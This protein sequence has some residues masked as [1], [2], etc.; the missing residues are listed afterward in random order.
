MGVMQS[1]KLNDIY[2]NIRYSMP[3]NK[4]DPLSLD[5]TA[6]R[7]LR[8]VHEF[9]SFSHAAESLGVTQS[10]VSYGIDRMRKA[11][12][13]PLFVRQGIDIVPTD[14]CSDIVA[15]ITPMI[16]EFMALSLSKDFDPAAS[17]ATVSLSCN[18]YERV[19]LL[20]GLMR[21][22]R[23]DA[24]RLRVNI[25]SSTVRGK[26]QLDR[27]E[28]D[29]LIGPIKVM[30]GSYY[31]RRLLDDHYVAVMSSANLLAGSS[32]T[33]DQYLSAPS[34]IVTYGGTW[35]SRVLQDIEHDGQSLN[36]VMEVPS[37]AHIPSLLHQT[38]LIATV[39][40]RIAQSYRGDVVIA[41]TPYPAPFE[42]DLSWTART[43]DSPLHGWVRGILARVAA[44]QA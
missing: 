22:L 32:L 17:T 15:T 33:K 23:R 2:R 10:T 8:L 29:M 25:L 30:Q 3:M 7:T 43:H 19:T 38:D 40:Y 4:L 5:F 12:G 26:E 20:P 6:L 31:R 35:R 14:R 9:R 24:P 42:I 36:A 41:D 28:S 44:D 1:N 16:D 21:H 34:V 18:Y 39:P 27:G 11:F 13:D 37:P